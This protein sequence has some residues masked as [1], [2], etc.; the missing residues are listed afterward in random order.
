MNNSEEHIDA[1][2]RGEMTIAEKEA[3]EIELEHNPT[4]AREVS[5]MRLVV[6]G[7]KERQEKLDAIKIW[8]DDVEQKSMNRLAVKH[9]WAPWVAAF[10]AAA[11]VV[12]GVF[13]FN[14]IPSPNL[15]PDVGSN[16]QVMRGTD[17]SEIDSLIEADKFQDAIEIIEAEIAE[18]DSLLQESIRARD[19]AIYA[20]QKYEYV[21]QLLEEKKNEILSKQRL[22]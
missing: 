5:M 1:Y 11:A 3:F 9:P 21:I 20:V 14:S 2:L 8:Q 16:P 17:L 12:A 15:P 6:C 13:L 22:K 18:N 19:E 4:L 10:S 7:L